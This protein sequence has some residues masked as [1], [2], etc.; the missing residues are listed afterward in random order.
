[1]KKAEDER[2]LG[3]AAAGFAGEAGPGQA[4]MGPSL[5]ADKA[6]VGGVDGPGNW[7]RAG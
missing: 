4:V 6:T 2:E 1:M 5:G 7:I 3:D